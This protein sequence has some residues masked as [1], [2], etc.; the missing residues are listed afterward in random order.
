MK[1][2]L[3]VPLGKERA[4]CA[5]CGCTA[6]RRMPVTL[7]NCGL[8]LEFQYEI[9]VCRRCRIEHRGAEHQ[10]SWGDLC[11]QAEAVN[12]REAGVVPS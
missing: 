8:H 4:F 5:I 12:P 7:R 3:Y 1:S 6:T 10:L 2:R 11:C 9:S